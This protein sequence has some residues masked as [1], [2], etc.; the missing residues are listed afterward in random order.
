MSLLD[1]RPS[2][3]ATKSFERG[4]C[5]ET[6]VRIIPIIM[7][8]IPHPRDGHNLRFRSEMLELEGNL[9]EDEGKSLD[10]SPNEL[11]CASGRRMC[12]APHG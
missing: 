11:Q 12:Q 1:Q 2:K 7:G 3:Y 9:W 6:R 4:G 5:L 8:M 10:L